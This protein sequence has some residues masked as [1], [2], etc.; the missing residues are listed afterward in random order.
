MRMSRNAICGRCRAKSASAS[1]P[2]SASATMSSAGH[3]S[4]SFSFSR[5][6]ISG[7]SSAISAVGR[8]I[9][10]QPPSSRAAAESE[11]S[12][13][14]SRM[15]AQNPCGSTSASSSDARSPNSS[16]RRSR[17]LA[18]P[19]PLADGPI[20]QAHAGVGYAQRERIAVTRDRHVDAAAAWRRLD[21]VLDRVLGERDQHARAV[22]ARRPTSCAT[23]TDHASRLPSRVPMMP[24]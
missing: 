3:T 22:S 4:A 7:S 18:R 14:G 6:R 23:S 12:G 24:R 5:S 15:R 1:S 21:A 20:V 13:A 10:Q 9:V 19:M 8:V 17:M 2:S 11:T 16:S